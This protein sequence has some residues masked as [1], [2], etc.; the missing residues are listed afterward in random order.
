MELKRWHYLTLSVFVA[1][2]IVALLV[3]SEQRA[4]LVS[5]LVAENDYL[6]RRLEQSREQLRQMTERQLELEAAIHNRTHSPAR[7]GRLDGWETMPVTTPSGLD[8]AELNQALAGTELAGLGEAL[9]AAEAATGVSAL[10]LAAI[11][12]HESG[13]GSSRLARD[14]NNLAG[15]GAYPGEEYSAGIS[16]ASRDGCVMFLARLLATHY[17]PGGKYYGGSYDLVGIG[18]SYAGDQG[19][20]EKVAGC[21][22]RIGGGWREW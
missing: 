11:C 14:K 7:G 12:A 5:D 20:A 8:A 9:I 10:V 15:L 4:A 19:W 16:F 18:R 21:M 2:A 3:A 1:G 6:T 17:A 13:W 22:E